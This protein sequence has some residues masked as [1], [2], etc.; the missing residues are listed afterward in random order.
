MKLRIEGLGKEIK[1]LLDELT[2]NDKCEVGKPSKEYQNY[3]NE[4]VRVY[5]DIEIIN[6]TQ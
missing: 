1:T 4:L 2:A 5:V 6:A 3:G